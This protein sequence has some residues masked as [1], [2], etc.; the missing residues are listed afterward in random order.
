VH[1]VSAKIK[2]DGGT[3]LLE[4]Q[5]PMALT[6]AQSSYFIL[7]VNGIR[8]YFS[9]YSIVN[10]T[11]E[12]TLMKNIHYSDI[13]TVSYVSGDIKAS[14]NGLL[15]GFSNLAVT[16]QVSEPAWI[17]IPAKAEAENFIFKSGM[18]TEA[19]S[20]V[21]GGLNLTN[22][23]DGNWAEYAI[24]NNTSQTDFQIAFRVAAPSTGGKINYYLDGVNIGNFSCPGT[25]GWQVYQSV[26]NNI[27]IAQGKH[28][29][30]MVATK[31]GFNINYMDI[32]GT[33]TGIRKSI[34]SDIEIYPN[35]ASDDM[36]IHSIDFRHNKIDVF[37]VTGNLVIS[38]ST[39]GEPVLHIPVNLSEGIYF[40]KI[41][42][43][44]Q[45]LFKKIV[46][47]NK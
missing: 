37:N 45:Y 7:N 21:G 36:V 28:Y 24:E 35:P 15:G 8:F 40:V 9:G 33:L 42:N 26:V 5:K 19:T 11:V 12:L 6:S 31:G 27:S 29:F 41:S 20:D 43:G 32:Y 14:D 30:K 38:V 3:L 4:F 2:P 16:N 47:S 13:V 46:I 34:E 25:G 23:S 39:G 10:N 1:I 18:Q 44:N 22:I 17:Q